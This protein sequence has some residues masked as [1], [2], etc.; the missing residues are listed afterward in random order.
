MSVFCYSHIMSNGK[1]LIRINAAEKRQRV[2]DA[3]AEG[4][5]WAKCAEI[6]GYSDATS[7]IR[8]F[9]QAMKE[10][11]HRNAE[12]WR[13]EHL[14]RLQADYAR[15]TKIIEFPPVKNT[16]TGHTQYDVRTCTCDVKGDIKR[17]H[18]DDC[19]VVPVLDEGKVIAAV[20][21]RR[22]IGESLRK[23]LGVDL[24]NAQDS[25]PADELTIQTLEYVRQL[26]PRVRELESQLD[27]V[28]QERDEMAREVGL[29]RSQLASWENGWLVQAQEVT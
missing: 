7:A 9:D 27:T 5:P 8:A 6:A 21:E 26:G 15:L 1:S 23:M 19:T 28:T 17:N 2:V 13:D 22:H 14:E 18:S 25:Q 29:L 3:R 12:Q 20:T 4:H 16:A 10:K 11:P 24:G